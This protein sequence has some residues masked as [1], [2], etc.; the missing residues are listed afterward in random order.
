MTS[1]RVRSWRRVRGCHERRRRSRT[2]A[3][4][5]SASTLGAV[6]SLGTVR[7]RSGRASSNPPLLSRG[8]AAIRRCN[9]RGCGGER[10]GTKR[11]RSTCGGDFA[12]AASRSLVREHRAATRAIYV[13]R[14]K[15]RCADPRRSRI[16]PGLA[17]SRARSR[18]RDVLA[19]DPAG[20]IRRYVPR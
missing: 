2:S 4:R 16:D 7:D 12:R 20:R 19:I 18:Q 9:R 15:N 14:F 17:G 5:K 3:G 1:V 10:A 11:S 8:M 6:S 13:T